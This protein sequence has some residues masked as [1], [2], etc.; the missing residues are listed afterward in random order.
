[1]TI[2]VLT[3]AALLSAAVIAVF[4]V[5]NLG[6][7]SLPGEGWYASD[8]AGMAFEPVAGPDGLEYALS[9]AARDADVRS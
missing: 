5:G 9:V 1:M 7:Q 3:R 2:R 6:A 4:L 8:A